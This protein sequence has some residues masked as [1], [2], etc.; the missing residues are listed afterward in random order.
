MNFLNMPVIDMTV[1]REFLVSVLKLTK[2]GP[3]HRK[4]V[5]KDARVPAEVVD[6]V[7][8]K[9]SSEE[10]IQQRKSLIE[11]DCSQ[12][13]KMAVQAVKLGAD[14]ERVCKFL[15]WTEFENIACE[16][17]EANNFKVKRHFRFK[18]AGKM[19]EIDVLGCKEPIIACVDCKHWHYGWRS[20]AIAKAAEAQVERTKAL[21]DVLPNLYEKAELN[22]WKHA[23]LIPI[24]L[25]LVSGPLKFHNNVPIVPVQ[26]LQ[27]FLNELPAQTD[28]LSHFS[29]KL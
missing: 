8:K 18:Q 28:R 25:S 12:R 2:I 20:T 13:A 16:T 29:K 1:E 15:H 9:L 14:F 26:Q 11:A 17:F 3:V 6:N 7:L 4:L 21:A 23:T 19:W 10:L 24:I 22:R 27:N 5:S